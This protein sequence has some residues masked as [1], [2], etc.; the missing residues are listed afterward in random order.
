MHRWFVYNAHF[1][2]FI[3]FHS[4]VRGI[5]NILWTPGWINFIFHILQSSLKLDVLADNKVFCE[6]LYSFFFCFSC[7]AFQGCES[8]CF[9]SPEGYTRGASEQCNQ[10]RWC[11]EAVSEELVPEWLEYCYHSQPPQV[12]SGFFSAYLEKINCRWSSYYVFCLPVQLMWWSR[13]LLQTAVCF[14]ILDFGNGVLGGAD[15]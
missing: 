9:T 15:K 3:S 4:L 12:V 2:A 13:E 1:D 6:V 8:P 5:R 11:L 14:S 10:S 7:S